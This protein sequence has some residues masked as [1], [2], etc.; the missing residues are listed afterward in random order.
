M[1]IEVEPDDV[2]EKNTDDRG[3]F[4]LGADFADR[5]DVEIAVLD[6]GEKADE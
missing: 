6:M 4:Y 1:K 5:D 3:R 2:M